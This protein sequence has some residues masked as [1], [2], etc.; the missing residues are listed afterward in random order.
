M[1]CVL[2]AVFVTS[3]TKRSVTEANIYGYTVI[4]DYSTIVCQLRVRKCALKPL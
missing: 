4:A 2:V 1:V 3:E